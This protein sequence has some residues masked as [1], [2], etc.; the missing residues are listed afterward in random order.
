MTKLDVHVPQSFHEIVGFQVY[1]NGMCHWL[2]E[3]APGDCLV[4][5][6]L[7]NEVFLTTPMPSDMVEIRTFINS[8]YEF[9]MA[10]IWWC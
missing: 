8:T 10:D 5:F 7:R 2:G 9:N 6:D 3:S 1:M 4:S